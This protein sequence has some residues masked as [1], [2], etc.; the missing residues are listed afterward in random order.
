MTVLMTGSATYKP[1]RS[2]QGFGKLLLRYGHRFLTNIVT[3]SWRVIKAAC[4]QWL[5]Y[6]RQ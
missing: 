4:L 1:E 6:I 2:M 5:M 3:F